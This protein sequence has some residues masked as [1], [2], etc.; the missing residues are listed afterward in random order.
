RLAMPSAASTSPMPPV[1]R[2]SQDTAGGGPRRRGVSVASGA[3]AASGV[4]ARCSSDAGGASGEASDAAGASGAAD[5]WFAGSSLEGV[6]GEASM[7]ASLS[8]VSGRFAGGD[9]LIRDRRRSLEQT[10]DAVVADSRGR[11]YAPLG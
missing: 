2:P 11:T 6:A 4:S 10:R 1:T 3:R 8:R 5:G 9:G 7:R